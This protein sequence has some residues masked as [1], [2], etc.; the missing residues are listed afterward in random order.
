MKVALPVFS[1]CTTCFPKYHIWQPCHLTARPNGSVTLPCTF[2]YTW[3]VQ[4]TAQV[5]WRLGNF[6][7]EFLFKHPHD[8][9][10][11]DTLPNYTGRVSLVGD[12][13]KGLDAS[14]QIENL[15]ESD[16]NLYFCTVSVQTLHDGV[17]HWRNIEGT[18]L[19]VTGELPHP[20]ED[21]SVSGSLLALCPTPVSAAPP[22]SPGLALFSARFKGVWGVCVWHW[23]LRQSRKWVSTLPQLR[24]GRV[25]KGI[26][27]PVAGSSASDA[28][29]RLQK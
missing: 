14:I 17:Q 18:N 13:S 11:R 25:P 4:E 28:P 15:Q 16:S 1:Y 6:Y 24:G 12:L 27:A 26:S 10:P 22:F 23:C 8:P 2:N 19:T 3:D 21:P 5:Y 29:P 7:G 9:T 20:Q